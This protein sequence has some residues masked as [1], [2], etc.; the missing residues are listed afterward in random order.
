[1]SAQDDPKNESMNL[2]ALSVP[3]M[4]TILEKAGGKPVDVERI[5]ADIAK[6]A[7]VDE[8]GNVNLLAYAAWLAKEAQAAGH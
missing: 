6:G 5:R 2:A 4:A 8:H 1:M 7:P 3:Q